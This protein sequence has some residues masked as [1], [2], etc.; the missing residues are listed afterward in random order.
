[1]NYTFTD[2]WVTFTK[3]SLFSVKG[4]LACSGSRIPGLKTE[5]KSFKIN[6]RIKDNG[7]CFSVSHLFVLKV[8]IE[9]V[10]RNKKPLKGMFRGSEGIDKG[11]VFIPSFLEGNP[12]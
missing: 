11:T 5:K 9:K 3:K 1:M 12:L 7:F 8:V 2:V 10:I 6:L 4:F